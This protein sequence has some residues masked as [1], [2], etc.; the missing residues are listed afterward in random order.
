MQAESVFAGQIAQS[1]VTYPQSVN[2]KYESLT[3]PSQES[4]ADN[5]DFYAL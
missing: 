4:L 2:S 5:Q 1:V 3:S